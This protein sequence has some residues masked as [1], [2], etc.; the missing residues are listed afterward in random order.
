MNLTFWGAAMLALAVSI[1]AF[2]A[3]GLQGKLD[4]YSMNIY[5]RAVLYH[6]IHALG[7]LLVAALVSSNAVSFSLGKWAGILLLAGIVFF[8][9]SLYVLALSGNRMWGAVTPIGG[10]SFIAGW[11]VLAVAGLKASRS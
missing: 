6:F 8:S 11:V 2:G 4:A 3:H 7:V 1:G 9:G 10:V 5:E